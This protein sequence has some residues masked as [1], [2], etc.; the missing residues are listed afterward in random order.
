VHNGFGDVIRRTSPDTGITDYEY[1]TA[2]NLTKMTD[3]RGVVTDY[4][5][6]VL[7][8]RISKTFPASTAENVTYS[9]DDVTGGNKGKGRLTKIEDSSGSTAFVYDARGNVTRQTRVIGTQTYVIDY[10][11]D[12]AG[13]LIRITYPSG[14][15]VEY[16]RDGEGR[17]AHVT[18][19]KTAGAAMTII[20]GA[21]T[22]MP[23]GPI[24]AL[25]FGNG[26]QATF[27]Y[28]ADCRLT[29]IDT[30]DGTSA[31][32]DLDYAYGDAGGGDAGN[33]R[34]ITD[35]LAP[36]LSQSFDYDAF[37]RLTGANGA[38]GDF[39]YTYD[40]VGNRLTRTITAGST[41]TETSTLDTASNRL[42]SVSDGTTTRALGYT[43]NGNIATDSAGAGFAYGY[44]HAN[45]VTTVQENSVTVA[46]YTYSDLG[47]RV[48]KDLGGGAIT[49]FLFDLG[50]ALLAESNAAGVVQRE[51]VHLGGLPLAVIAP[52]TSDTPTEFTVDNDSPDA[53][54]TGAWSTE[55]AG[56]G[57]EGTNY[58][59]RGGGEGLES[60]VWTPNIATASP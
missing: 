48:V 54:G 3:A 46:S 58:A 49:H 4:A 34:S 14:R 59:E 57:Y 39:D 22:Y 41:V 7:Y 6:D 52:G 21:I 20:A 25:T 35:N 18:T 32:Q 16:L 40:A 37:Y 33:I 15:L 56:A 36:S 12:A 28:D 50:G 53:G 42:L 47:E 55:T 1:D 17:V 5:Y 13:N 23:H 24:S 10:A 26:L 29:G 51:Y 9:Y 30:T 27:S 8:R 43:A 60:F 45:R 44:N 38:Y 31:V 19:R 11:Y 2:G